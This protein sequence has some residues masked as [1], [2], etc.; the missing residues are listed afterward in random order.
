M[1][2][3]SSDFLESYEAESELYDTGCSLLGTSDDEEYAES[4]SVVYEQSCSP[5]SVKT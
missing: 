1:P 4:R 3:V 5:L 2:L